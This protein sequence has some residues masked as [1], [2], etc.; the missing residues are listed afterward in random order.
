MLAAVLAGYVG[1]YVSQ[2][3]R[4]IIGHGT[5]VGMDNV[6]YL[7]WNRPGIMAENEV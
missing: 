1:L 7:R 5:L 6:D 2:W 4:H 3:V